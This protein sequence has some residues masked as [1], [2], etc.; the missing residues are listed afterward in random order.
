MR[1]ILCFGDS[2]TWGDPPGGHGR[3]T[4]NER[5]TGILQRLLGNG[6][7]VIE[8]GLSGRTTCFDDPFSP[9]RNGLAY[10]TVA[11]E[12]HYPLDLLIIMLGTND[13]KANFNL[14]TFDIGRGATSLL[15]A[16]KNF[17]PE[18]K[19]ILLVSPPHV[20]TTDDSGILQQFPDGIEK[21]RSLSLHYQRVAELHGCHFFNAASVAQASPIDGIH[22]DATN[23]KRLADGL[24][25]KIVNIF[26]FEAE[27]VG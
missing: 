1:E 22:L 2:N 15:V 20:A 27:W 17:K 16:A 13:L 10:L 26:E 5:W 23:H 4:W 24:A 6:F 18:I 9:N 7:R 12:T 11:L 3:F 21:S 25:R 19:H 8:E 14:S